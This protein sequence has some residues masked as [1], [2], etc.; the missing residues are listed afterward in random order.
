MGAGKS[1]ALQQCVVSIGRMRLLSSP[2]GEGRS[3]MSAL[4]RSQQL[5]LLAPS[6]IMRI[7]GE[8]THHQDSQRHT[9]RPR[10]SSARSAP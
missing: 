5:A 9:A 7:Q 4:H 8:A 3:L 10:P 6:Q 1:A 2:N